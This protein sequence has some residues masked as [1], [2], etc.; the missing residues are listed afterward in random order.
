MEHDENQVIRF[1]VELWFR[2]T[3]NK[4]QEARGQVGALITRLGRPILDDAIIS[5]IAYHALLAKVPADTAQ[6]I[7]DHPIVDLIKV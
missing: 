1:E 3:N 5:D 4:R 6:Q 2:A 7:I